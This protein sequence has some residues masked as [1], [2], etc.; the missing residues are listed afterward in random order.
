MNETDRLL[1][2]IDALQSLLAC[3]RTGRLPSDKLHRKLLATGTWEQQIRETPSDGNRP[4]I[5]TLCGSTRFPGLFQAA[6]LRETLA[7]RIVLTIGCD[8]MSDAD[9]AAVQALGGDPAEAKARLDVLHRRKIDL[10]DEVLILNQDGYI[11]EST[12]GELMYAVDAG[13]LVRWWECP[14]PAERLPAGA[15]QPCLS[16]GC[17][18]TPGRPHLPHVGGCLLNLDTDRP[19][20]LPGGTRA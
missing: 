3:Y 17:L 1:G 12:S 14:F 18:T 5:V 19:L 4:R 9:L 15:V 6:N 13:K 16:C 2:R 10:S 11:G 8:T 20:T 7:G